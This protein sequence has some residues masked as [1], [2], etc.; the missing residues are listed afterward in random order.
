MEEE[1]LDQVKEILPEIIL[2]EEEKLIE[3]LKE[4]YNNH[5]K[6]YKTN[7]NPYDNMNFLTFEECWPYISEVYAQLKHMNIKRIYL[8]NV[9]KLI[10]DPMHDKINYYI[11]ELTGY[12]GNIETE[13]KIEYKTKRNRKFKHPTEI[14]VN[15]N[16]IE[17]RIPY[18]KDWRDEISRK[19]NHALKIWS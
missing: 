17:I 12:T 9:Q 4:K 2:T 1:Q 3:H 16:K 7:K 19:L 5:V 13:I 14:R 10:L 18:S 11:I 15:I 8:S 6:Y